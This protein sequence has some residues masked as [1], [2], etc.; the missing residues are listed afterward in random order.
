MPRRQ[1]PL[2]GWHSFFQA[3][4]GIM[5]EL[6]SRL[7]DALSPLNIIA[8]TL[9]YPGEEVPHAQTE[10][11]TARSQTRGAQTPRGV[12]P[13]P[14][15]GPPRALSRTQ[16]L[17]PQRPGTGQVRDAAP[18]AR[19]WRLDQPLGRGVRSVTSFLLSGRGRLRGVRPGRARAAQ[20]RT[21]G[22]AQANPGG[23]RRHCRGQTGRHFV[24]G[25]GV[26][27]AAQAAARCL[28]APTQHRAWAGAA[29][30]IAVRAT[31]GSGPHVVDFTLHYEAL[32]NH[33]LN[34]AGQT[35]LSSG[36][37][38]LLHEGVAAWMRA[39]SQPELDA[40]D[41]PAILPTEPTHAR[42]TR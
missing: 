21:A 26:G 40:H 17:R 23:A 4:L 27:A 11:E 34:P 10:T 38:A 20:A 14:A 28:A 25:G 35:P 18:G 33:A 2:E 22:R 19:R 32:R 1:A 15:A 41:D 24:E 37:T 9:V 13:T 29:K 6:C 42:S 7:L 5:A 12:E 39:R 8:I 3:Y 36:L 16:L 31:A 30:K